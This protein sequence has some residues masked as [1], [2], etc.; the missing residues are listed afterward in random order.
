VWRVCC[1]CRAGFNLSLLTHYARAGCAWEALLW[2]PSHRAN[3]RE[4]TSAR[5]CI[6]PLFCLSIRLTGLCCR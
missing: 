2:V 3:L 5:E 1:V 6:C 4:G